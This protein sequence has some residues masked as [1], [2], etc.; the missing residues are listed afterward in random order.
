MRTYKVGIKIK[1]EGGAYSLYSATTTREA[2]DE[3]PIIQALLKSLKPFA[4]K[5]PQDKGD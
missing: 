4:P 5:G 3:Y 1:E 2:D